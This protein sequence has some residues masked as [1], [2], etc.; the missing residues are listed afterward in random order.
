[1][2]ASAWVPRMGT[3]RLHRKISASVAGEVQ[4]DLPQDGTQALDTRCADSQ[5]GDACNDLGQYYASVPFDPSLVPR[6]DEAFAYCLQ[7]EDSGTDTALACR[8]CGSEF[9]CDHSCALCKPAHML[10]CKPHVP[11]L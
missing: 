1:M 2:R 9:R 6:P 10:E 11:L 5:A 8:R 4:S 3:W 7:L